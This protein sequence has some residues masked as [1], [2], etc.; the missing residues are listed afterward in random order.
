MEKINIEKFSKELTKLID[1]KYPRTVAAVYLFGS[2]A[3]GYARPD[4]DIDVAA[5]FREGIADEVRDEASDLIMTVVGNLARVEDVNF[6]DLNRAQLLLRL[7]V[8]NDGF[9]IYDSARKERH[10]FEYRTLT[11]YEDEHKYMDEAIS[12]AFVQVSERGLQ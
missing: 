4:S 10:G 2:Y 1:E 8:I 5:L 6:V 9:V 3:K 12:A 7:N 11:E